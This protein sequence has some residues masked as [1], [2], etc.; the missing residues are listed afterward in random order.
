MAGSLR[1]FQYTTDAADIFLFRADESNIEGVNGTAANIAAGNDNLMGIPRNIKP[2][3]VFYGNAG[4]TRVIGVIA[5]TVA[6]YNTP[7]ATIPD[8]VAGTGNLT[9]VRKVPERMSMYPNFDT[10]LDDGDAPL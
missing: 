6:I 7:P 5:A 9:L 2:R 10:G 1:N 8:G 3:K 4:G